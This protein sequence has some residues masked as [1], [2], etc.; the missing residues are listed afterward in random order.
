MD[1][2]KNTPLHVAALNGNTD[3]I[4]VVIQHAADVNERGHFGRTALHHAYEKGH[5]ACVYELM[6]HGADVDVRGS[7]LESTPLQLTAHFDHSNCA[8]VL[9][10]HCGASINA[11]NKRGQTALHCAAVTGHL[12]VVATVVSFKQCDR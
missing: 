5:V 1:E 10:Q 7:E 8:K 6:T 9:L 3:V 4:N 2:D 12:D 11:T